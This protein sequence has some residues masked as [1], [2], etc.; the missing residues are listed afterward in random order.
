[1]KSKQAL[2][3]KYGL[4]TDSMAI[5][6]FLG[7]LSKKFNLNNSILNKYL[8]QLDELKRNLLGQ[9]ILSQESIK[10]PAGAL[11]AFDYFQILQQRVK[12]GI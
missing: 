4:M 1:M 12:L 7:G 5:D 10:Q 2:F 11:E 9:I 3:D 8:N 6:A